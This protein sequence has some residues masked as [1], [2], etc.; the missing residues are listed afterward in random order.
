MPVSIGPCPSADADPHA[1]RV[2]VVAQ[3][4]A[5]DNRFIVERDARHAAAPQAIPFDDDLVTRVDTAVA[6][7]QVDELVPRP[8][9]R[10]ARIDRSR[11]RPA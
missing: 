6:P 10:Q 5:A 9:G 4:D 11:A 7:A 1:M 2:A 3:R 8:G